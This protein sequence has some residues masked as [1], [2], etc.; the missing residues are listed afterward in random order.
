M[1]SPFWGKASS[2]DHKQSQF[3]SGGSGSLPFGFDHIILVVGTQI[4]PTYEGVPVEFTMHLIDQLTNVLFE[5][6]TTDFIAL[7]LLT[8]A[9][10]TSYG[11]II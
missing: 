11:N 9:I 4:C 1:S 5:T 2:S 8:V 3:L 7:H 10:T 6:Q